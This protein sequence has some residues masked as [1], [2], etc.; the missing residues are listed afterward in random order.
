MG[1]ASSTSENPS[2]FQY[3]FTKVH[4]EASVSGIEN[5]LD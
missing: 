4:G 3:T 5:K 2:V 1:S